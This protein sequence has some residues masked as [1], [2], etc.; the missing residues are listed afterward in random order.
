MSFRFKVSHLTVYLS[1]FEMESKMLIEWK[2]LNKIKEIKIE[3][4][5]NN[6]IV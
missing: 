4:S 1:L 6:T 5:E 2:R 3:L